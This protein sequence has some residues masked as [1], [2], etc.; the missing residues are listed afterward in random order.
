M[1]VV[2]WVRGVTQLHDIIYIVCEESSA[3]LR[4]NSTTHQRLTD[5]NVRDLSDP[6]DIVACEQTS[7]IY[8]CD[9][10]CIW[11]V[12]AVG[13]DI[14]RWLPK[15]PSVT[16]QPDKLSV[17]SSRLLVTSD[18]THQVTQLSLIHI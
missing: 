5:I 13:E 9:W 7:H 15:S 1:S 18:H 2:V 3:I 8:V 6:I 4:F 17:T 12:S 10:N 11:L 14:K 16:F